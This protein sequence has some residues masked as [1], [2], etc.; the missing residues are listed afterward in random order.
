MK[1]YIYKI[2]CTDVNITEIYVGSTRDAKERKSH[3]KGVCNNPTDRNHN[4]P[5]YQFIRANGGWENWTLII[6]ETI[7]YNEKH[8]L[9]AREHH[10]IETLKAT[11]NCQV[12]TRT[13]KEW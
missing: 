4:T 5:V 8:E 1:G 13:D 12:P 10:W 7:E 2:Y 9:R 3:H 6:I 11:L